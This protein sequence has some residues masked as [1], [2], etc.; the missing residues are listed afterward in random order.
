MTIGKLLKDLRKKKSIRQGIAAKEV[1]IS[2][3]WLSL[4]EQ[5]KR[6]PSTVMLRR[7][8]RYY[9]IPT[10]V[11]SWLSLS[12]EDISEDKKESFRRIKPTMDAL[13]NEIFEIK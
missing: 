8:S 5:D 12:L 13:I 1:G 6:I 4:I 9:N 7:L 10:P 3:T 11:I 2:Q